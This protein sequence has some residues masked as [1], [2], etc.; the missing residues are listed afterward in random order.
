MRTIWVGLPAQFMSRNDFQY[1]IHSKDK[2]V[3]E[4]IVGDNRLV[5]FMGGTSVGIMRYLALRKKK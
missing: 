5:L 1:P 3:D 2:I 4:L